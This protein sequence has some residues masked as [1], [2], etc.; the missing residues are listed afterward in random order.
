MQEAV[1]LPHENI[2]INIIITVIKIII[3]IINIITVTTVI[4]IT[5]VCVLYGFKWYYCQ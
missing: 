5:F 2:I 3:T 1:Q 4:T